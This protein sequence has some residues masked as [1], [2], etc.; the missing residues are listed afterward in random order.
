MANTAA[1]A[2]DGGK[3]QES[4]LSASVKA[5]ALLDQLLQGLGE[6]EKRVARVVL[7]HWLSTLSDANSQVHARRSAERMG[8]A[9][10]CEEKSEN[11]ESVLPSVAMEARADEL[12]EACAEK[13]LLLSAAA[14][15]RHHLCRSYS[16]HL[17]PQTPSQANGPCCSSCF[18]PTCRRVTRLA[19]EKRAGLPMLCDCACPAAVE[20]A[21]CGI[22]S[23]TAAAWTGV[24]ADAPL[25]TVTCV[26]TA[27]GAAATAAAAAVGVSSDSLHAACTVASNL[28]C[29]AL[30][31]QL[32]AA[33]QNEA[34]QANEKVL[35]RVIYSLYCGKSTSSMRRPEQLDAVAAGHAVVLPAKVNDEAT[36]CCS[37]GSEAERF[38]EF[39]PNSGKQGCH[40]LV[41]LDSSSPLPLLPTT[42]SALISHAEQT[43]D[44]DLLL[45]L[46]AISQ[47]SSQVSRSADSSPR[48]DSGSLALRS[49]GDRVL[50][51]V[52]SARNHVEKEKVR[53][54]LTLSDT[55]ALVLRGVGTAS[56]SWRRFCVR[57][58]GTES[59]SSAGRTGARTSVATEDNA[60][61]LQ[62]CHT[63]G[64]SDRNGVQME[65]SQESV[66]TFK[67]G[68]FAPAD[69]SKGL[70]DEGSVAATRTSTMND[71]GNVPVAVSAALSSALMGDDCWEENVAAAAFPLE[72]GGEGPRDKVVV[73]RLSSPCS[74]SRNTP[75][76]VPGPSDVPAASVEQ[77]LLSLT[78]DAMS[79]TSCSSELSSAATSSFTCV[80]GRASCQLCYCPNDEHV[81]PE[82]AATEAAAIMRGF[83]RLGADATRDPNEA[84]FELLRKTPCMPPP[85]LT[86]GSG[87]RMRMGKGGGAGS[88]NRTSEVQSNLE[89][90]Q[91]TDGSLATVHDGEK[92]PTENDEGERKLEASEEGMLAAT[93]LLNSLS[94]QCGRGDGPTSQADDHQDIDTELAQ[95]FLHL[96]QACSG[97]RKPTGVN[98]EKSV[99]VLRKGHDFEG[100]K[101]VASDTNLYLRGGQGGAADHTASTT[102]CLSVDTK[103]SADSVAE[104]ACRKASKPI[105]SA[106]GGSARPSTAA[107]KMSRSLGVG[108]HVVSASTSSYSLPQTLVTNNAGGRADSV[109]GATDNVG[110]GQ[111]AESG[112]QSGTGGQWTD[113][114]SGDDVYR[115]GVR[116]RHLGRTG[117]VKAC[118]TVWSKLKNSRGLQPNAV[119]Y[120]CMYD[121]LVSN[122]RVVEAL[123]LFEEMKR[124]GQV[125]PNTIMY[126][127]II[128]GF[129]QS[130][131]LDRA[132]KMYAEMQQN[133]VAIN[134]VTFNSI[135]DAC[136]RVGAMDKAAMLLEDMLS[137]GI[138]PDLITF[139]T[140]IKGYCVHGE[141]NKALHLLKAMRERH[142]KPD[143][144]LYN[145]L[146][147]GCVKTGRVSLCEYLWEEMQREEIPPSNFTLTILI[148]MHGRLYQLQKAFDLVKELPRKYGFSINAHVYT[149]LMAA[150]IVNREYYLAL[151]VYDCM[152]RSGVRGDPKTLTTI[153]GGCI[154]GRMI[155]EAVNI[156]SR[157][158]DQMVPSGG[159]A[160]NIQG[161]DLGPSQHTGLTLVDEKTLRFVIQQTK[162]HGLAEEL[163]LPLVHKA[164]SVGLLRGRNAMTALHAVGSYSTPALPV[165]P[166]RPTSDG[167][168]QRNS[169][170]TFPRASSRCGISSV[171]NGVDGLPVSYSQSDRHDIGV[172]SLPTGRAGACSSVQG[173]SP[174]VH[175]AAVPY[176]ACFD[177]INQLGYPEQRHQGEVNEDSAFAS[178]AAYAIPSA[179]RLDADSVP[180]KPSANPQRET[181]TYALSSNCPRLEQY[182]EASWQCGGKS[183]QD[184]AVSASRPIGE[185]PRVTSAQNGVGGSCAVRTT[186]SSCVND[187]SACRQTL[188]VEP[189]VQADSALRVGSTQG[190]SGDGVD[191]SLLPTLLSVNLS[192]S[193]GPRVRS[194]QVSRETISRRHREE[195]HEVCAEIGRASARGEMMIL[196]AR[197]QSPGV[198]ESYVDTST[199]KLDNRGLDSFGRADG[200]TE[201][202]PASLV[203]SMAS[204]MH[205]QQLMALP[206]ERVLVGTPDGLT[207][208]SQEGN[209]E[210]YASGPRA[211]ST[212]KGSSRFLLQHRR[213]VRGHQMPCNNSGLSVSS[214]SGVFG[215]GDPLSTSESGTEECSWSNGHGLQRFGI[216]CGH[217]RQPAFGDGCRPHGRLHFQPPPPPYSSSGVSCG[218]PVP[219][220]TENGYGGGGRRRRQAQAQ[221]MWRA[222]ARH[223]PRKEGC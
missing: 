91:Q 120:G 132:L 152:E 5:T 67:M 108:S 133:G 207:G 57:T 30:R 193:G 122:G 188:N 189:Y 19:P 165:V 169:Q 160:P 58:G 142:I 102:D 206:L 210:F 8:D 31:A 47:D 130:K 51:S 49:A 113:E 183:H 175:E 65:A 146:L 187:Q 209:F 191:G 119:A 78:S 38:P 97:Q 106:S 223:P 166:P 104:T 100:A 96:V 55:S 87:V 41:E 44:K 7:R 63:D 161:G 68:I 135:V 174:G 99:L 32:R 77:F 76:R 149:C 12:A 220:A 151:E 145:S 195:I 22:S 158:L 202:D 140:I 81:R 112:G 3:T 153:V 201:R 72:E 89:A 222:D 105:H 71:S 50:D 4:V 216:R 82:A 114:R 107:G 69:H 134:T 137:Q 163:G 83:Q 43:R 93:A 217:A 27:A 28:V 21:L 192:T 70:S 212:G 126:S 208:F 182:S 53:P 115:Y 154:K 190:T 184:M 92:S 214:I 52:N 101:Q 144:V 54:F 121:A 117:K 111:E 147:D 45:L 26:S 75:P 221:N 162:A 15:L 10:P 40:P 86:R 46:L 34:E 199:S 95:R 143:G 148:K 16:R 138:K 88:N 13:D 39:V 164:I 136:A 2:G 84:L 178:C 203:S 213:G 180:K 172:M 85:G 110:N 219:G 125:P 168:K 131:Q 59:D 56:A 129:A 181:D 42:F 198:S 66:P 124:E 156:V 62:Q 118:W 167:P 186:S 18:A 11:G 35:S 139:S 194:Q 150:C 20:R 176:G 9:S 127:T 1:F 218:A 61:L 73:P 94:I 159:S 211:A 29:A 60:G 80:C 155:R 90:L 128:K 141:M 197:P 103:N 14:A 204:P 37:T 173:I 171:L 205:A 64:D 179:L 185:V 196:R 116:L 33:S 17:Q 98:S 170:G 215:V 123:E 48:R 24:S 23:A 109:E 200:A 157:A 25:Q 177:D 79:T 74:E 36:L 6:E